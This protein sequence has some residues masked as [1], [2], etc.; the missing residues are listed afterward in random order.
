MKSMYISV[1]F[2]IAVAAGLVF[3]TPAQPAAAT[4]GPL[5]YYRFP[6]IHDETIVFTAEGDLWRVPIAAALPSA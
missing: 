6:T 3:S 5:G 2:C 1:T 4:D